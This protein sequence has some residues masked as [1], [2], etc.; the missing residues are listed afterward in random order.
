VLLGDNDTTRNTLTGSIL[1]LHQYPDQYRKLRA[2]PELIDGMIQEAIRWQSPAAHMRRTALQDAEV[3]GRL[4]KKGDRV[5]MWY[6]SGN[7]DDEVIDNPDS[8]H[9]RSRS[10]EDTPVVRIRYPPLRRLAACEISAPN[11]LGRDVETLQRD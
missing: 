1:A 11:H 6:V 3:G 4:I 5:V 10:S 7:C 9:H 2:Q 8:F